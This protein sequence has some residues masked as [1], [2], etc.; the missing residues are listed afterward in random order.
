MTR[1]I[2]NAQKII[3]GILIFFL[4]NF[5]IFSQ[6]NEKVHPSLEPLFIAQDYLDN[7]TNMSA[8]SADEVFRLSLLFSECPLDSNEGI[9]CLKIFDTI[10]ATVTSL[11]YMNLSPEDRGRAVLKF[12]YQDYLKVY[13]AKQTRTSVALLTGEYNCVSSA[14]I[15]MAAAKAAGLDVRGQKTPDHAFCTIYTPKKFD[16]ETTN[17]YGFNPGSKEAVENQD[18]IKGYYIVPKK[19]YSNRQEVSDRIFVGL[20]AG[21]ICSDCVLQDDYQKAVP[22]GAAYYELVRSEKSVAANQA[23]KDFDILA[24][25]YVNTDI[26]DAQIFSGIVDWYTSFIDRWGMT[27]F[28]QKNMDNA[29]ANLLVLCFQEKKPEFARTS[30]EKNKKYLT[31]KQYDTCQ[32]MVIDITFSVAIENTSPENQIEIINQTLALPENQT[33]VIQKRGQLYLENAWLMILNDFMNARNYTDGYKKS[34]E[35][36]KQLPKSSKIKNMRQSFYNNSITIIHNNFA[37]QANKRNVDAALKILE[38]GLQQFPDDKTLKKDMSDFQRM[39]QNTS[40]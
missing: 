15:Y 33:D 13:E 6:T 14:L 36:L 29:Q 22:I 24:A 38:E 5:C 18:K 40:L 10:K 1:K 35:A 39:L 8:F 26:E 32:E 31:Q 21:N 12:L 17:P 25:N 3:A 11:E 19:Y 37:D 7:P 28:L 4:F 20:V 34:E 27:D 2:N 30:L 9:T 23:R 16:V